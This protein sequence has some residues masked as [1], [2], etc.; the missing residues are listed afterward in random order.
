MTYKKNY[1]KPEFKVIVMSHKSRLLSNS[2]PLRTTY[3]PTENAS[4]E[5]M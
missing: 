4:E 1:Q 2:D 5:G 3:D